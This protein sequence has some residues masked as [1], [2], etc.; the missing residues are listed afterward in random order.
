MQPL[1]LEIYW[2]RTWALEPPCLGPNS[3]CNSESYESVPWLPH[4]LERGKVVSI[5]LVRRVTWASTSLERGQCL[6]NRNTREMTSGP[7]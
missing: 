3:D 2:L 5:S 1:S 6:A 4:L 7:F